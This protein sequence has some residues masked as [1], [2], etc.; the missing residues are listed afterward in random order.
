MYVFLLT[1][2]KEVLN[3]LKQGASQSPQRVETSG[4]SGDETDTSKGRRKILSKKI[5]RMKKV[6]AATEL[7]RFFATRPSDAANMPCHFFCRVCLKNVSV[8]THGIIKCCGISKAVVTLP[9]ISAWVWKHRVLDFHG[10]PLSEDE[11]ERQRKTIR[12]G[13]F[14]VRDREHPFAEDL[15]TDESGVVDSQLPVLTKVSCLV[16]ALK[17]GGS[18]ELIAKLWAQLVLTA[19]P[20]NSEV[21]WTSDEVLVGSVDFRNHFVSFLIPIV[22]LFLVNH[23]NWNA[24]PNFVAPVWLGEGSPFYNLEFEER[25]VLLWAF[26]R[27][28]QKDTFSGCCGRYRPFCRWCYTRV[29]S[30]RV[31]CG[32]CGWF[33]VLRPRCCF[34]RV[35]CVGRHLQRVSGKWVQ[36]QGGRVPSVRS[37]KRC[38]QK[39]SSSVQSG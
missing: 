4:T 15:I 37:S 8:L 23:R 14:A 20:V 19:G 11:L 31:N 29:V 33:S 38:L 30:A 6:Y 32:C 24:T 7:G 18:Y 3:R 5:F 36:S 1:E 12:N 28:W 27:T 9:V 2:L 10:N 34:W 16:D 17:M 25:D 13:P 26:M 22:V 39:V 35:A 21:A